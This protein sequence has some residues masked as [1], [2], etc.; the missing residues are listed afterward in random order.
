MSGPGVAQHASTPSRIPSPKDEMTPTTV[1][2]TLNGAISRWL[3]GISPKI[4]ESLSRSEGG[5]WRGGGGGESFVPF[6]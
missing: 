2:H 1:T 6:C 3:A 5:I 4:H